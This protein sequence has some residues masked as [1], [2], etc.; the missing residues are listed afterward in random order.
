MSTKQTLTC[1]FCKQNIIRW[2]Y[3][4]QQI[5]NTKNY[6]CK[7]CKSV[8]SKEKR[9][10]PVCN[11][12]FEVYKREK[13]V[14]CSR[15]CSNT[16]YRVGPNNGNW[17]DSVYRSTCFAKHKRVCIVCGE[18]KIVA[19]HH[20]DENRNN[21]NIENLIPMCPTHHQ[22]MHSKHKN[23]ILKQVQDYIKKFKRAVA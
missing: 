8:N 7:N 18:D 16:H 13:K 23:L 3:E 17:K 9:T 6:V 15:S 11:K 2:K 14:T 22:Y 19:V 12:I 10:C 4:V 5:K 1:K 20:F 21:N